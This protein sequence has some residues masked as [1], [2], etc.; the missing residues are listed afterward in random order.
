[1]CYVYEVQSCFPHISDVIWILFFCVCGRSVRWA[2]VDRNQNGHWIIGINT[3]NEV[4]TLFMNP[5]HSMVAN[6]MDCILFDMFNHAK[7]TP[8]ALVPINS[9]SAEN[10]VFVVVGLFN[11]FL[12]FVTEIVLSWNCKRSA[13]GYSLPQ[14]D[15]N[16]DDDSTSHQSRKHLHS[17]LYHRLCHHHI[18]NSWIGD[19]NDAW[20]L[21]RA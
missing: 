8:T 12:S 9:R 6:P 1:M 17:S 18:R 2:S 3:P 16:A 11:V 13:N 21:R 19:T 7:C 20:H 4:H 10:V 15:D 14:R 5:K